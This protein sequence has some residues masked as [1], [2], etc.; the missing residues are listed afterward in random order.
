MMKKLVLQKQEDED[1]NAGL[2]YLFSLYYSLAIF[3]HYSLILE[4]TG[5]SEGN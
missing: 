5:K 1:Q 3:I 2:K 4:N